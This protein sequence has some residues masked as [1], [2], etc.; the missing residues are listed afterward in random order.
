[1]NRS[2][3]LFFFGLRGLCVMFFSFCIVLL[4]TI[5]CALA[6]DPASS[7]LCY[8]LTQS[9]DGSGATRVS[10]TTQIPS[11][12]PQD[13]NGE[14]AWWFGIEPSN[15]LY[16]IQPILPKWLGDGYYIFNEMFDWHTF[17]DQQ[18]TNIKIPYGTNVSAEI[19]TRD[20]GK[21]YTMTVKAQGHQWNLTV[22]TYK[23]DG[24]FTNVYFVLEHQVDRCSQLPSAGS[25]S[26][27]D[28]EI[29]FGGKRV[30]PQ[31]STHLERPVC[32]SQVKVISPSS[33]SIEWDPQQEKQRRPLHKERSSYHH[34]E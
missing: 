25:L 27:T 7:W 20:G 4:A 19:I 18:S 29:E 1:M 16:L 12:P 26:Y 32:K 2:F 33:L 31:W 24:P 21:H 34:E 3:R 28:I 11:G 13:P 30:V 23:D 6:Q 9:S 5:T 14:P 10:A 15:N 22:P 8:A 17:N